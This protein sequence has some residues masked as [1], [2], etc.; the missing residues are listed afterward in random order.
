MKKWSIFKFL[1]F[2]AICF[3]SCNNENAEQ[4]SADEYY[5]KYE[6][7]S[8]TSPYIGGTMDV[9]ISAENNKEMTFVIN[10]STTWETIIGPVN[11]GFNA[12]LSV[13]SASNYFGYLKIN[14]QISVSKIGSP[15]ALKKNDEKIGATSVQ[16][17]YTIDY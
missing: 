11:K 1:F 6:I 16:I 7:K 15:F 3:S 17:N 13:T 4:N 14:A 12:R 5:V 10:S 8:S 9:A 2:M